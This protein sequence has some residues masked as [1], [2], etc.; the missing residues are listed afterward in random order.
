MPATIPRWNLRRWWWAALVGAM[1]LGCA[2]PCIDGDFIRD[3]HLY[4]VAN[5]HVVAA[6][7]LTEI[8]AAPFAPD[9]DLGLWRPLTTLSFRMDMLLAHAFGRELPDPRTAHLTNL[10][11]AALSSALLVRLALQLGIAPTAALLAGLFFAVAAARTEAVC[12]MSGRA[13]N[14]MT[15]ATLA[16]LLAAGLRGWKRTFGVAAACACAVLSK[17]QGLLVPVLVALLPSAN[18]VAPLTGVAQWRFRWQ[19]TWPALAV[20]AALLLLRWNVLGNFGPTGLQQVLRGSSFGERLHYGLENLGNYARLCLLPWPLSNDYDAP[21]GSVHWSALLWCA[22]AFAALLLAALRS[23]RGCFAAAMWLVPLIP[24]LNIFVRTGEVFAERFLALP[25]AGAALLLAHAASGARML[26]S[27]RPHWYLL[28]LTLLVALNLP[29]TQQRARAWQSEAALVQSMQAADVPDAGALRL[30]A[31]LQRGALVSQAALGAADPAAAE[32]LASSYRAVLARAPHD[33][34]TALDLAKHMKAMA[35]APESPTPRKTQLRA[36]AESTVL[37][38][39]AR[40][41][42]NAHAF[43]V[44]GEI[45]SAQGRP[46]ESIVAFRRARELDGR[47]ANAALWLARLLR[48]LGRESEARMELAVARAVIEGLQRERWWDTQPCFALARLCVAQEDSVGTCAAF[49]VAHER[50]RSAPVVAQAA[51]EHAEVLRALK[52]NDEANRVLLTASAKL[53]D[54]EHENAPTPR[55]DRYAALTQLAMALGQRDAALHWLEKNSTVARDA[56][57]L[58]G[59]ALLR[60]RLQQATPAAR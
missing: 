7:P 58:R 8:F 22:A 26:R 2:W 51:M 11:L 54:D 10:L 47:D 3:D 28:P 42:S 5:P 19:R 37:G 16:A 23:Q 24:V 20:A 57:A 40:D 46:E 15:A 29:L 35:M 38:V 49:T 48:A 41:A 59:L 32:Q 18:G 6:A 14:L 39:I 50:A 31:Y 44:L 33:V 4:I 43:A 45:L 30:A 55:S 52:R 60:E 9:Q 27:L 25:V 13:E 17:E 12:W 36:A 1:A 34:E 21:D 53:E 56:Q